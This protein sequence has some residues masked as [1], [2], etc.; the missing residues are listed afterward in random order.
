MQDEA[1]E[2]KKPTK[3]K[4]AS[5]STNK[6]DDS[7][8]EEEEGPPQKMPVRVVGVRSM[9]FEQPPQFDIH[10]HSEC[11]EYW[12]LKSTAT[13]ELKRLPKLI[14]ASSYISCLR[15]S[16]LFAKLKKGDVRLRTIIDGA[17][18]KDYQE[19]DMIYQ[20]D[21]IASTMCIISEGSFKVVRESDPDNPKQSKKSVKELTA[22]IDAQKLH[23]FGELCILQ[24]GKRTETLIAKSM[25]VTAVWIH[26]DDVAQACRVDEHDNGIETLMKTQSTTVPKVFAT[27]RSKVLGYSEKNIEDSRVDMGGPQRWGEELTAEDRVRARV[28]A[29]KVDKKTGKKA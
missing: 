12:R 4:G 7:Y 29:G 20:Q 19:G 8:D 27:L 6:D 22:D 9:M 18:E 3:K 14:G 2:E 26:A 17:E 5:K 24:T 23:R 11:A 21:S 15:A 25:L 28:H 13:G 1:K 16:P 10:V